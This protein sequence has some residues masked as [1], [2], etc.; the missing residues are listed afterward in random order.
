MDGAWS[1]EMRMQSPVSLAI[2]TSPTAHVISTLFELW[3]Q[4]DALMSAGS[5]FVALDL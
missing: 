5:N 1:A 4:A 2:Q 3:S